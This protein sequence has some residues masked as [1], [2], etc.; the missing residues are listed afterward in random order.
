MM[1]NIPICFLIMVLVLFSC[2]NESSDNK[3]P[4]KTDQKELASDTIQKKEIGTISHLIDYSL[5]DELLSLVFGES[6]SDY[7]SFNYSISNDNQ[8]SFI[9]K[10]KA[11]QAFTSQESIANF[12]DGNFDYLNNEGLVVVID[13]GV[14]SKDWLNSLDRLISLKE[15]GDNTRKLSEI[16][17]G[18]IVVVLENYS[19]FIFINHCADRPRFEKAATFL[20]SQNDVLRLEVSRCGFN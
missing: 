13:Q 15:R 19:L 4:V 8:L 16:K 20:E 1:K 5:R 12:T 2:L 7:K 14:K 17:P 6:T 9:F 11:Y 10:E 3:Y 18:F